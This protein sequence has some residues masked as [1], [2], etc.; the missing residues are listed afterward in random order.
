[1]AF[2]SLPPPHWERPVTV[3]SQDTGCS[4]W[5]LPVGADGQMSR[6][7]GGRRGKGREDK[8]YSKAGSLAETTYWCFSRRETGKPGVL[9]GNWVGTLS[10]RGVLP[11]C[12]FC[13]CCVSLFPTPSS[14]DWALAPLPQSQTLIPDNKVLYF[15]SFGF[16]F[17]W[18]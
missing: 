16:L 6:R 17:S 5:V 4:C 1:M 9:L 15:W 8:V 10:G 14:W 7:G 13:V 3:N 12:A 11:I 2:S 18:N